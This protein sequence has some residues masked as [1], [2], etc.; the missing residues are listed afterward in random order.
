MKIDSA[1]NINEFKSSNS[2]LGRKL[3]DF[4]V[5]NSNIASALKKLLT[6]DFKR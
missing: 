5:F 4:E 3:P 6:T 2:V 1:R